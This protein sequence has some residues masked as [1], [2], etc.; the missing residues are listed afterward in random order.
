V[1]PIPE[2]PEAMVIC[3]GDRSRTDLAE[4]TFLDGRYTVRSRSGLNPAERLI[5]DGLGRLRD[6]K[7]VLV[8]GNRTGVCAMIAR[9]LYPD[10]ALT[11]HCLDLYRANR[12]GRNLSEHGTPGVTVRCEPFITER[13]THDAIF[14]QATKGG[15]AGELLADILQDGHRALADGGR[16]FVCLESRFSWADAPVKKLFDRCSATEGEDGSRR[17]VGRKTRP[18]KKVRNHEAEITMT[19]QGRLPVTLVTL[20]GVFSHRR[21]DQGGQ[22]L[23]E[24]VRPSRGDSVLDMGCGSGVVGISIARNTELARLVLVDSNTRAVHVTERNCRLN[25]LEDAEVVLSDTGVDMPGEF[26]LAVGNPPYFTEYRIAEMFVR[27]MH[28]ALAPSGR[29]YVVAKNAAWHHTFMDRIFGNAE[30]IKRRGY[31]IIR[32]VKAFEADSVYTDL[33]AWGDDDEDGVPQRADHG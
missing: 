32:A 31:Q 28:K 11:I 21:V 9:D 5:I 18:L 16:C 30:L 12:I 22:A 19:M 4:E 1:I 7:S 6:P 27:T 23:A 29:A 33:T 3:N 8:L 20:P 25:G 10:A 17:L 13:D 2:R 14:I 26:S 24:V 15:I